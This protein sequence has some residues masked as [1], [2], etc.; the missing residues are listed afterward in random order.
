MRNHVG[1]VLLFLMLLSGQWA[2]PS[3]TC[4][5]PTLGHFGATEL[6]RLKAVAAEGSAAVARWDLQMGLSYTGNFSRLAINVSALSQTDGD[7]FGPAY[8]LNGLTDRGY[9]YQVG[10]AFNWPYLSGGFDPGFHLL[11]G[12]FAPNG[13][14]ILPSGGGGGISDFDGVVSD[15]DTILLT[16]NF[17]GGNVIMA[18]YDWE[19][20]ARTYASYPSFFASSFVGNEEYPKGNRGFFTGL[21]TEW[22]HASPSYS[23]FASVTYSSSDPVASSVWLWGDQWNVFTNQ[24][25]YQDSYPYLI[26]FT[27]PAQLFQLNTHGMTSFVNST[28]FIT[29]LIPLRLDRFIDNTPPNEEGLKAVLAFYVRVLGGQPP[30][31][32]ELFLDDVSVQTST[33]D[34]NELNV[35]SYVPYPKEGIH[36]YHVVVVD[37]MGASI[38]SPI[39]LLPVLPKLAI[40]STT[41]TSYSQSPVYVGTSVDVRVN[42][43]GGSRPYTY[44]WYVDGSPVRTSSSDSLTYSFSTL[45]HHSLEVV[46]VDY[47]GASVSGQTVI[48]EHT[49]NYAFFATMALALFIIGGLVL[50]IRRRRADMAHRTPSELAQLWD[51]PCAFK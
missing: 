1:A 17:T 23:N 18:A 41:V 22:Y 24:V 36:S 45:G 11:F 43:T 10:L 50:T 51:E 13:T 30:Y 33:S 21:M 25:L 38:A 47:I 34:D 40:V 14:V 20:G 44:I 5:Q 49:Y 35:T 8:L 31:Q 48:V 12:V 7:G 4:I 32:Y 3:P 2:M 46:V 42:V 28:H 15:G 19:S 29:G 27:D 9:W 39:N 26:N 6:P 16:M 37:A